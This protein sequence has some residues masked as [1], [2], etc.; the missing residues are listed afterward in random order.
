MRKLPAFLL[1]MVVF[2]T[3][4]AFA[5]EDP[6]STLTGIVEKYL[7]AK[8]PRSKGTMR[9]AVY[10]VKDRTW[11]AFQW[12]GKKVVETSK[13]IDVSFTNDATLLVKKGED[14]A[15][16]VA[17][18]NPLMYSTEVTSVSRADIEG[19]DDLK[20]L[21]ALFGTSLQAVVTRTS[22]TPQEV[23]ENPTS[24]D[25][26]LFSRRLRD[27]GEPFMTMEKAKQE[28]KRRRKSLDELVADYLEQLE[29]IHATLKKTIEAAE[30]PIKTARNRPLAIDTLRQ[31]IVEGLQDAELGTTPLG[32]DTIK[33]LP[34]LRAT[35][36]KEFADAAQAAETLGDAE[37]PC[38][39]SITAL[40]TVLRLVVEPMPKDPD[41]A[42]E[43]RSSLRK[44]FRI[45]RPVALEEDC[46]TKDPKTRSRAHTADL[47]DRTS[48]LIQWLEDP[49]NR[50]TAAADD[51]VAT[52]LED[53]RSNSAK[54]VA[55]VDK[56]TRLLEAEETIEEKR[57]AT[58]KVA[59]ELQRFGALFKSSEIGGLA[60]WQT[61]GIVEVDRAQQNGLSL[62]WYEVQ[63]EEY[64]MTVRPQFA[65]D[66]LRDL[67]NEVKGKYTFS[68][69]NYGFDVDT[70]LMFTHANDRE[71]KAVSRPV[72]EDVNED[73]KINNEDTKLFVSET[74]RADRTGKLALM[75]TASPDFMRGFGVQFGLGVDTDNPAAFIGV[76]RSFAKFM[77]IS[78]GHT[79]Q[80]VTRL[81]TDVNLGDV[82]LSA[83]DLR[84][85]ERFDASWYAAV[86]FTISKLPIFNTGD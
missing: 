60:C 63:T 46:P 12:D 36:T 72:N 82:L 62:P 55:A 57:A 48:D 17:H 44:A 67:P 29:P 15:V 26:Q 38:S 78:A 74:S 23:V 71:Y 9:I 5:E 45:L 54:Y 30:R 35:A 58:L 65:E 7:T 42:D 69:G 40:E 39:A 20:K 79:Q 66:V 41:E 10:D 31:K 33:D 21:A 1:M 76:T 59:T 75:L 61:A 34:T 84:T 85:R 4:L 52:L 80:R 43:V 77:R 22:L 86:A 68:R 81:G 3:P 28:V 14:V 13:A 6:C 24:A 56:R 64:T 11:H 8:H 19:L 18:A 25:A 32:A 27:L 47:H 53:A 50:A 2:F 70:A 16:L 37:T 83:D 49:Q 73:G 51:A